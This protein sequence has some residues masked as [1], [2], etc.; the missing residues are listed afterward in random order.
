MVKG[1]TR[2]VI[3]IKSPDT[4]Y[5]EEAIFVVRDDVFRER[6]A[7]SAAIIKEA[8]KIASS[9]VSGGKFRP[10]K[11]TLSLP[12]PLFAAAG[13]AATAAAWLTV[14]LCGL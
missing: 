11:K 13:A 2:R 14:S 4:R 6:G 12:A 7:D 3:V 8:Q 1:V 9:Y 5:F 10:L